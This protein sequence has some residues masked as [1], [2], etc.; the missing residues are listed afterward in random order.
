MATP[1]ISSSKN[2]SSFFIWTADNFPKLSPSS[3][4]ITKSGFQLCLFFHSL[5]YPLK[6]NHTTPL[7][8]GLLILPSETLG[9][10]S[11]KSQDQGIVPPTSSQLFSKDS[12]V[13]WKR[14]VPHRLMYL[15]IW[16]LVCGR[17]W[18]GYLGGGALLEEVC[19]EGHDLR[20][21]SLVPFLVRVCLSRFPCPDDMW[22]PDFP[23]L[24]PHHDDTSQDGLDPPGNIS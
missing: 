4:L 16:S 5:L 11:T 2:I 24:P 15:D 14:R 17:V 1:L 9:P 13:V 3:H 22:L 10:S 23:L 19:H 8:F 12:G 20:V 18:R 6:S 7:I 21:Y